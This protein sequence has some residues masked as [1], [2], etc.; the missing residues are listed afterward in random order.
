[1]STDFEVLAEMGL[2]AEF[3][4]LNDI[5]LNGQKI[6]GNAQTRK[7]GGIAAWDFAFGCGR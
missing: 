2:Q 6:S 5:I 1:M 3:A 4:P 7:R